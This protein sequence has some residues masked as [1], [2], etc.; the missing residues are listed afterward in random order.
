MGLI[1]LFIRKPSIKFSPSPLENVTQAS[2]WGIIIHDLE[3]TTLLRGRIVIKM[4]TLLIFILIFIWLLRLIRRLILNEYQL[5]F[6]VR[7]LITLR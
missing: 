6:F 2:F 5:L 3:S 4:R 1:L 7:L